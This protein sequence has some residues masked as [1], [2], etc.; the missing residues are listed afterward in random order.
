MQTKPTPSNG[1]PPLARL[2]LTV[3]STGRRGKRVGCFKMRV[4][5]SRAFG[6]GQIGTIARYYGYRH[7]STPAFA[8]GFRLGNFG[9]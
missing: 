2:A 1:L 5:A 7:Q 6:V 8:S 9:A 4:P 3:S